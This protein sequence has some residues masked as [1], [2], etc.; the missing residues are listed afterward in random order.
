VKKVEENQMEKLKLAILGAGNIA[1]NMARTI[2]EMEDVEAYAIGA[3]DLAKAEEFA[4]TYGFQKAYGSYEEMVKDDEIDLIYIATPHSHHYQHGK[5]CLTHGKHVLC[6]KAFTA[7]AKQ[8]EELVDLAKEKN[9]LLAEAI[10]TRYMP[11]VAAMREVMNSG[12]IGTPSFLT[13]NLGYPIA[14]IPRMQDPALAGGSLLDLGVYTLNF[15]AML[16]GDKIKK[17]TA[18][19]T[20]T[21][22]GMDE[23]DVIV[24]EYEDGRVANLS[25]TMMGASDRKGI[26]YGSKGY[27]VIENINNFESITVFDKD[28]KQLL[29]KEREQQ[30]TGFE[31]QV[32]ACKEAIEKNQGECEAMPH[33]EI[34]RI[35]KQMDEIRGIL[36]VR[37]P[38]E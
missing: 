35:M 14:N 38:F 1:G 9:L 25:C 8:A 23:S 22:T 30:I 6:E 29:F 18:T 24:L 7:T 3:R 20:Y 2:R 28:H 34:L 37:Y 15:A 36:G 17:T 21:A 26:I 27:M 5:L 31:Y 4:N 13:A 12:I 19:C 16:F 32:R 33:G 11:M 10:W